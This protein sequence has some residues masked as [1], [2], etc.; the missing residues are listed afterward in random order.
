MDELKASPQVEHGYIRIANEL[1][2]AILIYP[3]KGAELKITFT[4]IRMT[5]GW[6][7]KKHQL[8]FFQLS[9]LANVSQRHAK[10][11]VK[12]LVQDKVLIKEKSQ[13]NNVL[14]INKNYYSWR[15]WKTQKIGDRFATA[16]VT[17]LSLEK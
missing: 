2:D 1:M 9:C 10:R 13:N 15:L 6:K 4:I 7:R 11:I 3:F 17:S 8:G 5:Y 14:G 16:E 12:R